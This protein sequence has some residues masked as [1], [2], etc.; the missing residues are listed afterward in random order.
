[1]CACKIIGIDY[2]NDD[3]KEHTFNLEHS[4]NIMHVFSRVRASR[5]MNSS[6]S[7]QRSYV[8]PALNCRRRVVRLTIYRG[9]RCRSRETSGTKKCIAMHTPAHTADRAAPVVKARD[10]TA[11][12]RRD[13]VIHGSG[14]YRR[15][16]PRRSP[17][18]TT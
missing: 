15:S 17:K 3:P 5:K 9:A 14:E 10:G 1:M 11:R 12:R 16:Q 8:A 18:R 7:N 2:F 4:A 6:A 13:D